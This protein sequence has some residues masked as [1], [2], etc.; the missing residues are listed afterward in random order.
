[1]RCRIYILQKVRNSR[2]T[3]FKE[4]TKTFLSGKLSAT[5]IIPIEI[6]R[7]YGLEKP[8]HVVVEER[9]EGILIRRLEI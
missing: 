1:K 2:M 6:A 9:P 3:E 4:I 7:R 5:L 8:A